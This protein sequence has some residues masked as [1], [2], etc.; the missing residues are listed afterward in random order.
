MKRAAADSLDAPLPTDPIADDSNG[1]PDMWLNEELEALGELKRGAIAAQFPE[2]FNVDSDILNGAS[3]VWLP[4]RL[5][6]EIAPGEFQE[7]LKKHGSQLS[8]MEDSVHRRKSILSYSYNNNDGTDDPQQPEMGMRY[9]TDL[10]NSGD[11][12]LD[13]VDFS[14]GVGAGVRRRNT[15]GLVRRKT[16]IERA[17]EEADE[18]A[19]FLVQGMQRSSLKRSKLANK[20]RDSTASR[21]GSGRRGRRNYD[22]AAPSVSSPLA[23]PTVD[24]AEDDDGEND[25]ETA[26]NNSNGGSSANAKLSHAS[27]KQQHHPQKSRASAHENA[28]SP[29]SRHPISSSFLS[30]QQQSLELTRDAPTSV[31]FDSDG[32]RMSTAEI[33]KQVTAA[34]D[35]LGFDFEIC[36][37]DNYDDLATPEP[38]APTLASIN[39]ADDKQQQQ[40]YQMSPNAADQEKPATLERKSVT[41]KK[42]GSWWQWGRDDN[43]TNGP[44]TSGPGISS[45]EKDA[46]PPMTLPNTI[47]R[48]KQQPLQKQQ[49]QPPQASAN[50]PSSIKHAE[51]MP[52]APSS[53]LL[54][55]KLP[56]P[57]SF[58]R[59]NRKSKKDRRSSD[60]NQQQ[61]QQQQHQQQPTGIVQPHNLSNAPQPSQTKQQPLGLG[62]GH[63]KQQHQGPSAASAPTSAPLT[64]SSGLQPSNAQQKREMK[65]AQAN[66]D[67][68]ST[69]TSSDSEGSSNGAAQKSNIPSIITPVRPPPTRLAT[70]S[71]RLPIHIERAI[72][73]LASI[74]LANPRRP[75]LQQVLL[76]NMMFWYLELINPR[77]QQ[78]QQQT[79]QPPSPQ[80]AQQQHQQAQPE[81]KQKS[82][83]MTQTQPQQTPP[84]A[85]QQQQQPQQQQQQH[86]IHKQH[87]QKQQQHRAPSPEVGGM[88]GHHHGATDK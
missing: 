57:I 69:D 17:D 68:G 13:N 5:H 43:A 15:T 21:T 19:P 71:N 3:N 56:S 77:S 84:V 59:F 24:T 65:D 22:H 75:L 25:D 80:Q 18:D 36:D 78:Q 26:T 50:V 61:Q 31:E 9:S 79:Q 11:D 48:P 87:H 23:P 42:S 46:R 88:N 35:N 10:N 82:P 64:A 7:W 6:P 1:T 44:S 72:Y 58:L 62:P 8:K 2:E 66:D 60:G 14:F 74:K 16:F 33:L 27:R 30:G 39:S 76:S 53:S 54:K 20:R 45:G 29:D 40:P 73:R 70:S 55:S 41:H 67:S 37:L 86:Q 12:A 51:T 83:K 81:K 28:E 52:A 63:K 85:A 34:V 4:A 49:Q 47:Q 32:K 38:S